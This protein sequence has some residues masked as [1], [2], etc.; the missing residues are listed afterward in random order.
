MECLIPGLILVGLMI[1]ASTRLKRATADAFDRETIETE[2]FY[3]QKPE[4]FLHNLHPDPEY[5]FEAYS[6]EFS[7]EHPDIRIGTARIKK[8]VGESVERVA[9]KVLGSDY[10]PEGYSLEDYLDTSDKRLYSFDVI[11]REDGGVQTETHYKFGEAY[12]SVYVLEVRALEGSWDD[13]WVEA[14]FDSFRI[15]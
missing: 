6:K 2:E 7:R 4:G 11:R 5:V 1:Y 9:V 3:I 12:G 14:F 13:Q 10:I 15:K 8:F